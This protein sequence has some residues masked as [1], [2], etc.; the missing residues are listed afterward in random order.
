MKKTIVIVCA[1]AALVLLLLTCPDKKAHQDKIKSVVL[2]YTLGD[3]VNTLGGA[4]GSM[5]IGN[6]ADIYLE[7]NL[8]YHNYL[9]FSTCQLPANQGDKTVSYGVLNQIF[10]FDNEDISNA[11]SNVN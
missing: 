3:E 1:V 4:L 9:L 2:N 7:N 11:I 5:L 6:A 8:V 10:T